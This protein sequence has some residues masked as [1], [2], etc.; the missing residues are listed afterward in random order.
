[1]RAFKSNRRPLW[2]KKR[3]RYKRLLVKFVYH[4]Y[5]RF[6]SFFVGRYRLKRRSRK[7]SI[8]LKDI[9]VETRKKLQEIWDL[10]FKVVV[11]P[12][13]YRLDKLNGVF[14]EKFITNKSFIY[15]RLFK[16]FFFWII[17]FFQ[18][19]FQYYLK[20]LINSWF[21]YFYL[22]AFDFQ[23]YLEF[24]YRK[25]INP[26][27]FY[28]YNLEFFSKYTSVF[29]YNLSYVVGKLYEY[30]DLSEEEIILPNRLRSNMKFTSFW[31][32]V[33]LRK[34]KRFYFS[35]IIKKSHAYDQR[36]KRNELAGIETKPR[37]KRNPRF[38]RFFL[39]KGRQRIVIDD[40]DIDED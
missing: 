40:L 10:G 22:I 27:F 4:K 14:L 25:N 28:Y 39:K 6:Y 20:F 23:N 7:D 32:W 33:N 30:C 8:C 24:F 12:S 21:R 35:N 26:V 18:C 17:F 5:K 2:H 36:L 15:F 31:T 34:I 11:R 3:L 29:H 38:R 13:A 9:S 16:L 37:R 19:Y 1:V